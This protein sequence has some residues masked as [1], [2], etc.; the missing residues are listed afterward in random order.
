M[1]FR[2]LEADEIEARV[3]TV[4]EKGCSVLLYKDARCD[5]RIL[6]ETVGPENWQRSHEVVNNNLFCNC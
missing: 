1:N 5:M 3:S 6:D 2:L 4:T